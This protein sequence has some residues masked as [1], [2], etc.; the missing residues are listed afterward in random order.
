MDLVDIGRRAAAV[1]MA[2]AIIASIIALAVFS[3]GADPE[4]LSVPLFIGTRPFYSSVKDL[5]A[6]IPSGEVSVTDIMWYGLSSMVGVMLTFLSI[7]LTMYL[8]LSAT[9][10]QIV[11]Q[12]VLYIVSPLIFIFSFIQL[13][14]WIYYVSKITETISTV[15]HGS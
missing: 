11:P 5:S 13:C 14:V 7:T 12:D 3:G 9:I 6:S 4:L 1:S 2:T 8:L 15:I 10:I